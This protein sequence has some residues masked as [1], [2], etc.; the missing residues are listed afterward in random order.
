MEAGLKRLELMKKNQYLYKDQNAIIIDRLEKYAKGE[1]DSLALLEGLGPEDKA[2]VYLTLNAMLDYKEKEVRYFIP[3]PMDPY[4]NY[5][6]CP[7]ISAGIEEKTD[8]RNVYVD[9]IGPEPINEWW[10]GLYSSYYYE[11]DGDF[12]SIPNGAVIYPSDWIKIVSK[13]PDLAQTVFNLMKSDYEYGYKHPFVTVDDAIAMIEKEL[14]WA[15]N[16]PDANNV[17]YKGKEHAQ[18]IPDEVIETI[19]IVRPVERVTL[20][21]IV[22]GDFGT[23]QELKNINVSDGGQS[24]PGE[25]IKR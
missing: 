16:N 14:K 9:R 21:E 2:K 13:N 25:K 23:Y 6:E 12:S 5:S 15:Q 24:K 8:F 18:H 10:G 17:W 3:R 1:I 19:S 4:L 22:R 11:L 7:A 20:E